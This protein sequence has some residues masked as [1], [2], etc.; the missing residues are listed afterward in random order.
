MNEKISDGSKQK[1]YM[2]DDKEDWIDHCARKFTPEEFRGAMRFTIGRYALR[3]G[4]KDPEEI[5]KS[6]MDDYQR[7]WDLYET[8]D[9]TKIEARMRNHI[10][11]WEPV[12]DR[13]LPKEVIEELLW[14]STVFPD[15]HDILFSWGDEDNED[16]PHVANYVADTHN[17][18]KFM[19]D[20]REFL[21][22]NLN[23]D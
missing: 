1:R 23:E 3:M 20:M 10:F 8:M 17:E 19:I 4:K 6:K 11:Y 12:V 22:E 15:H 18:Y 2:V 9:R 5:E 16:S 21:L 14:L 7:R 13:S